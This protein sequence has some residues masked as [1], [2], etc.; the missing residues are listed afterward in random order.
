LNIGEVLANARSTLT[1]G[2][3]SVVG[4]KIALRWLDIL[5]SQTLCLR[6]RE[7]ET[8]V[9]GQ[10][11]RR[12]DELMENTYEAILSEFQLEAEGGTGNYH[13]LTALRLLECLPGGRQSGPGILVSSVCEC[14]GD[15]IVAIACL[16]WPP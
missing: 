2:T 12:L 4:I 6:R 16:T 11:G 5:E 7:G 1:Q 13:Y 10:D 15:E 3:T 14:Y 9:L 8:V